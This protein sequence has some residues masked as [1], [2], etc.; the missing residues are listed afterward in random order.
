MVAVRDI[1]LIRN[2]L[3]YAEAVLKAFCEFV[4]GGFQRGSVEAEIYIMLC[5]PP[6][7]GGVHVL[8]NLKRKGGCGGIGMALSGHIFYALIQSRV[9]ERDGGISAVE[10]LV[11]RLALFEAGAGSALPQNRRRVG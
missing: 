10:Q 7:A 6:A 9:A 2:T 8:H 3:N 1:S 4:G 11:D 5:L